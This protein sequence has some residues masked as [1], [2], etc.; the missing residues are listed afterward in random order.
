MPLPVKLLA[1]AAMLAFSGARLSAEQIDDPLV[2]V[3]TLYN[4]ALIEGDGNALRSTLGSQVSMFNGAGSSRLSDWEPHMY[5]SGE[6]V[7]QWANFM[8]SAAGPHEN[9]VKTVS[10]EERGNMALVVSLETGRNKFLSWEQSERLYLLGRQDGN[11]KIVGL[12]LPDAS[13]PQ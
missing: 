2:D 10:V 12:F 13:N 3:V 11:W 9:T 8:V 4:Q 7:Q 6:E 1:L 5:L